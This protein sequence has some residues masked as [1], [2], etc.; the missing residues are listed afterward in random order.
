MRASPLLV[1]HAEGHGDHRDHHGRESGRVPDPRQLVV[2]H[3]GDPEKPQAEA[4]CR[5][6]VDPLADEPD[7]QCRGDERLGPHHQ[8]RDAGLD[9]EVERDPHSA[10]PDPVQQQADHRHVRVVDSP[11][12]PRRA[13]HDRGEREQRRGG[14]E[15]QGEEPHRPGVRHRDGHD[16]VAGAPQE[17]EQRGE[18]GRT[19]HRR[20]VHVLHR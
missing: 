9:P 6:A 4:G 5:A 20:I 7:R 10:E 14:P 18:R 11:V 12:R 3:Q 19:D 17:H 8:R 13:E 16:Q 1:E 15:A 2:D